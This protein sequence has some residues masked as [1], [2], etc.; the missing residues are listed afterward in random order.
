M[1]CN[2]QAKQQLHHVDWSLFRRAHFLHR[3]QHLS[4][5]RRHLGHQEMALFARTLMQSVKI[6]AVVSPHLHTIVS[7]GLLRPE[8]GARVS[9]QPSEVHFT[10]NR[11]F[12]I[13]R[14]TA[15]HSG[16]SDL[17]VTDNP[18][19]STGSDCE[20]VAVVRPRFRRGQLGRQR[21]RVAGL[22]GEEIRA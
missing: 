8:Q 14:R 6:S 2:N 5:D 20:Q 17:S 7:S 3:D 22:D 1:Y 15:L 13:H 19:R 12:Q 16:M 9:R 11:R 4:L 10:R 18:C 21:R